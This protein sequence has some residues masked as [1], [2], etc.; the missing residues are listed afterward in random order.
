MIEKSLD[1]VIAEWLIWC[2]VMIVTGIMC[3]HLI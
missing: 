3:G 2:D 1:M